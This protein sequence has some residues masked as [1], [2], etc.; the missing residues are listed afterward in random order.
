MTIGLLQA[1]FQ[2]VLI[3]VIKQNDMDLKTH[4]VAVH[5][6]K[7]IKANLSNYVKGTNT[8]MSSSQTA[9]IARSKRP[10]I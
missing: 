2:D 7:L 5:K 6:D 3:P 9:S 4:N 1:Y 8:P 10:D